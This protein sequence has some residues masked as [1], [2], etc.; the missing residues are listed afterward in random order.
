MASPTIN[1]LVTSISTP[2]IT[3]TA[4]T[5]VTIGALYLYGGLYN[6]LYCILSGFLSGFLYCE[7]WCLTLLVNRNILICY[8]SLFYILSKGCFLFVVKLYKIIINHKNGGGIWNSSSRSSYWGTFGIS[9]KSLKSLS[10][11]FLRFGFCFLIGWLIF[12]PFSSIHCG[13]FYW[14]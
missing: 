7:V 5:L 14:F 9:L 12:L 3:G 6:V 2:T 8:N 1:T 10:L 4:M 11:F 13:L